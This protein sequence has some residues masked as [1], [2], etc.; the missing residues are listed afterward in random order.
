M[1]QRADK[2]ELNKVFNF[3]KIIFTNITQ[4]IPP[5]FS[6][7]TVLPI[8]RHPIQPGQHQAPEASPRKSRASISSTASLVCLE[9]SKIRG[10]SVGRNMGLEAGYARDLKGRWGVDGRCGIK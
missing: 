3:F 7:S 2:S 1:A 8:N 10:D 6:K 9:R 4:S 5:L